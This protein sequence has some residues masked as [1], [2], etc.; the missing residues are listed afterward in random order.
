VTHPEHQDTNEKQ[1]QEGDNSSGMF[2]IFVV[3]SIHGD[4]ARLDI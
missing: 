4:H 1:D 2:T 3:W